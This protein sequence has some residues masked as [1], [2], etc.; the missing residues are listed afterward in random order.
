MWSESTE[1][2][3]CEMSTVKTLSYICVEEKLNCFCMLNCDVQSIWCIT[4]SVE[5]TG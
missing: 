2:V 4:D 5:T 1:V 3:V